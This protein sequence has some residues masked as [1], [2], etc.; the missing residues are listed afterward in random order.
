MTMMGACHW[1]VAIFS[2]LSF[3]PSAAVF[4]DCLSPPAAAVLHFSCSTHC[5]TRHGAREAKFYIVYHAKNEEAGREREKLRENFPTVNG[6]HVLLA[7]TLRRRRTPRNDFSA[8]NGKKELS[9]ILSLL[10]F[11]HN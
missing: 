3:P 10:E 2:F 1:Q 7:V 5:S 8:I 6:G 11:V 9:L 4:Y